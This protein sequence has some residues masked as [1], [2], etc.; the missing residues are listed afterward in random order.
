MNVIKK[1]GVRQE[2]NSKKI[3][4]AVS[5]SAERVNAELT[6]SEQHKLLSLVCKEVAGLGEISV[7]DLHIVVEN[8]LQQ[9]N[10][11]ISKSY[12]EYRNYKTDFVQLL[13]NIYSKTKD[14][15]YFG[16]KENS[17]AESTLV[18][19]KGSLIKGYL[20][21]EIYKKFHLPKDELEAIED[22]YIYAHDLRDL[23]FNGINCCLFDIG[24]VLKGGF[25]M[26]NLKYSEP[27]SVLSALQ[28]I[29]DVTL[30]ASAQQYGGFTLAQIDEVL[31]PYMHKT[32][33]NMYGEAELFGVSDPDKY[34]YYK[35]KDELRQGFQS[36]EMKLNSIP[37]ARGDFAFT[38]FTFGNL[39]EGD[40]REFQ[41]MACETLL[42]VR[43][44]GQG[45]GET[46]VFPKLVFLFSQDQYDKHKDYQLLVDLGIE[47]SSKAMYPDWLAIDT[48]GVV[49]DYYKKGGA[50]V[51]PMG[52][53]AYLSDYYDTNGDMYFIGRANVGAVSLNLPMIWQKSNGDS[54][55]EDLEY[56]LEMI[57]RFHKRKY[58]AIAN[59]PCSS[60]PLAFCQGGLRGGNKE[61]TDKIGYDMV[62]SFTSSFGVT[63]L[64]ELNVLMEGLP[65]HESD[66]AKVNE[67]VDFIAEKV[68]GYKQTDGWSYALY[69]TPAESLAGTQREQFVKKFGV[70]EGVSDRSYFSNGF[71]AHVTAD[72]TPYEKQ[73]VE[74]ELFHKLNGGHIQYVRINNPKNIDAIKSVV[75]RGMEK[76]F[77]QGV[78]F[79]LVVCEDCGHRPSK[80]VD[81]CPMCK[82]KRIMSI[83][84]ACG[85]ISY[86]KVNGD[87]RFNDAKLDEINERKSM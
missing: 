20:A 71:H 23:L 2:W 75:L 80:D 41:R 31:V 76:G 62:K 11:K 13:D 52:C 16:D 60:N 6:A 66:Q 7:S 22:G 70:I 55:Y 3:I 29:G 18:S 84:R 4:S 64:N 78:N 63:A 51:S 72:I 44:K 65:L 81:E 69:C 17:N 24:T 25:E 26:S 32:W 56:Y 12:S 74:E 9:V 57:R 87:T 85:Y 1:N 43:K 19:T 40:D 36:L 45:K 61:L 27:N 49:S 21:K 67:V 68:T 42:E 39:T 50:I 37:S 14:T 82:S 59:T 5:K 58:E 15:L 34:A 53:R 33:S 38:T 47:C 73:D 77:Y 30:A 83:S 54:F 46:V 28:V 8:C 10:E 35:L 86:R 48:V 79:D